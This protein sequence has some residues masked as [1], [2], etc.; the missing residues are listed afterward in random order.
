MDEGACD[1]GGERGCD[2]EEAGGIGHG[3]Q[4]PYSYSWRGESIVAGVEVS[5]SIY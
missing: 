2:E 1:C 5:V 3:G 4:R